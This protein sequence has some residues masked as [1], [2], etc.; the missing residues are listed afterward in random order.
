MLDQVLT[1]LTAQ[2]PLI[3]AIVGLI[4]MGA[5]I[6]GAIQLVLLR[7]RNAARE[8]ALRNERETPPD[9][10]A[11]GAVRTLLDLGLSQQSELEDLISVRTVNIATF[12]LLMITLWGAIAGL[13][14]SG[15]IILT[16]INGAVFLAALL[17]LVLHAGGRHLAA[18]WL[19]LLVVIFYWVII[20]IVVG[21]FAGLEYFVPIIMVAP[22][23]LF[24]KRE[25]RAIILAVSLICMAVIAALVL[26]RSVPHTLGMESGFFQ[27]GYYVNAVLITLALFVMI[28]FY[29]NFAATSFHD[30]E[31]EKLR[32]DELV[33]S[34]LPAYVAERVQNQ[35]STVA[36]WH[37]EATVLF[38]NIRGFETLHNRVSAVQLVEM[39]GELFTRFDELIKKHG[40]D[41]VNTLGTNYV[42][43]SGIGEDGETRHAA[44]AMFALDAL[45]A[46]RSF[47]QSV[48]HPFRLRA[49]ISTGQVVSGVIGDVRPCFDIWGETVE[50]ANSLRDSAVDNSI[51][52]NE[53][54]YWRLK[55]QFEFAAIDES[56]AAY[57]LL[58]MKT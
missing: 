50:L 53:P 57:I 49:G 21:P 31:T 17:V 12:C 36:D 39:L 58:R 54:A 32:T 19:F 51:V 40:I 38:V 3:S 26:Q 23:L 37:G 43:A 47:S 45:A 55:E 22:I 35:Q 9:G 1:V 18:K 42:V 11:P 7:G 5:A 46:V 2:E 52:V 8:E 15:M 44:V 25:K 14:V 16:V 30:L 13:F 33:N 20:M 27:F 10:Q 56:E 34:L 48:N 24:S 41:K 28:N 29:N 6:W 4:T